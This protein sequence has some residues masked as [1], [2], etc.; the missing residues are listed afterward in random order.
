MKGYSDAV[1]DRGIQSGEAS[2]CRT[3]NSQEAYVQDE[4]RAVTYNY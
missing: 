4:A 2:E 1:S 3:S